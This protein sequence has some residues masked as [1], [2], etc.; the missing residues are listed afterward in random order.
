MVS[1]RLIRR[2]QVICKRKFPKNWISFSQFSSC[3]CQRTTAP[4][5]CDGHEDDH[6]RNEEIF[7]YSH[8]DDVMQFDAVIQDTAPSGSYHGTVIACHGAPGSHE[9]FKYFLPYLK[10]MGVRF[11]G[12][13]FP[14]FGYTA[15]HPKLR[16]DNRERLEFAQQIVKHLDSNAKLVFVG[17]SRG[18]ETA[19]K[20]SVLN[21]ERTAAVV[22]INPVTLLVYRGLRPLWRIRLF[23]WLWNL[24]NIAQFILK[25]AV[26]LDTWSSCEPIRVMLLRHQL[27]R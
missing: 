15:S 1:L 21:K 25:P 6:L 12:I 14:G 18:S 19:L 3:A 23:A 20:L 10:N 8:D 4:I 26:Y 11:V 13:N 9:D 16:Y 22:L 17:H 24:G 2:L 5:N 27:C 7:I